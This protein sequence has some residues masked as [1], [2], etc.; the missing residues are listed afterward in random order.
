[1]KDEKLKLMDL[2]VSHT[3]GVEY[4]LIT[5]HGLFIMNR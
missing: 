5:K 1:M 2:H 4:G 3:L